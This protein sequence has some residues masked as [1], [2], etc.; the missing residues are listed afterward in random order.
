MPPSP[1]KPL[2]VEGAALVLINRYGDDCAMV[3]FLRALHCTRR[4]D[5][6]A[7]REWRLVCRRVVELHFAP[8]RGPAH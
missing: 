4:N 3:A 6:A 8:R 5:E 1:R 7:A 2:N